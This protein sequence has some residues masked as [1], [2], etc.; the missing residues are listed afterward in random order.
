MKVYAFSDGAAQGSP[1]PAGIGGVI[2]DEQGEV[3][4]KLSQPIGVADSAFAEWTAIVSLLRQAQG[5]GATEIELNLDEAGIVDALCDAATIRAPHLVPY[6]EE[7]RKLM[8]QFINCDVVYI[9]RS[10]NTIADGLAG[11][12]AGANQ[13]YRYLKRNAVRLW[14]QRKDRL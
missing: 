13:N 12:A 3:L 8:A 4:A 9:P 7:A 6:Y 5:L 10:G 14:A 1:G 2:Y 11:G